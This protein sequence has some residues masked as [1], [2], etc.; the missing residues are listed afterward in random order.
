MTLRR[1]AFAAF[2]VLVPACA[3]G[4]DT[5][6]TAAWEAESSGAGEPSSS[7]SAASESSEAP[8]PSSGSGEDTA[9][10]DSGGPATD[11]PAVD[12]CPRIRVVTPP[13]EPLNVRPDPSTAGEPIG[14][15]VNG[16]L[17]TVID[18]VVGEAVEGN[19]QW[20]DIEYQGSHGY[21][22][23]VFAECTLDEPPEPPDG[24]YLPLP[25]GMAV[26]CT[27]GNMGVTSHN[28][29]HA[30]AFDFGIGLDT[31][32]VAMADGV[33]SLIY[34]ATVPGDPC[35]DGGGPECGPS[36]NLVIIVHGDDTATLY[37]HLNVV[38]VAPGDEVSR[39]QQ[40]GLSG[41]T[42]Y[43]TGPHVHVMRMENCGSLRCQSMPMEFVDAGVPVEG[44]PVVSQNCI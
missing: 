21:V 23:G 36:G 37:K 7:S 6:S 12:D 40:I 42:G 20:F 25:C 16:T 38:Q 14:S 19:T 5:R 15:L 17:A 43:S 31:P 24:Y 28:G 1:S 9:P 32:L 18:E 44:T 27:Q 35:Y 8:S 29:L 2:Y 34:D 26:N 3:G 39:G 13:S 22:S 10:V 33:V 41:T 30:Y 4:A 11:V